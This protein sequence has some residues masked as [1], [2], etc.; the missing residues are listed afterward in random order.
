MD[1]KPTKAFQVDS[2]GVYAIDKQL[3]LF[4]IDKVTLKCDVNDGSVVNGIREPKL[5]SFIL[6]KAAGY[7]VF[8][9]PETIQFKN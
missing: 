4:K 6:D 1:Y 9:Q 5:F 7:K 2:P 8:C 3:N